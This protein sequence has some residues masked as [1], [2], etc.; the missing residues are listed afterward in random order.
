MD[1]PVT[2]IYDANVL[3]PA[4][5]R[6]LFLRIAQSGLVFAR[7]TEL[8]HD[9]WVRNLLEN[10]P[11]MNPES[12]AR[13]RRLINE[14]VRDCLVTG[15]EGLIDTVDLPDPDDRHVLAAAIHADA[16]A[17]ITYNLKDFPGQAL[18]RYGIESLHPDEFLSSL[19]AT[20]P[21]SV[22]SVIKRQRESFADHP[23]RLWNS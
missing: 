13:T 15:Y 3:Y 23:T 14:A 18:S 7:W 17:I 16:H 5:I 21:G 10:N 2:A 9:E 11:K 12:I 8:I 19:I 1:H 6:D 4:P 22:C 20:V